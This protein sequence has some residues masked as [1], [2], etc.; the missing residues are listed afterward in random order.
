MRLQLRD[1]LNTIQRIYGL[2]ELELLGHESA[3]FEPCE[4][5]CENGGGCWTHRDT[6]C[7]CVRSWYG[8]L[9]YRTAAR[10]LFLRPY[11]AHFCPVFLVFSRFSPS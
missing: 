8:P 10:T 7:T 5:S 11:L 2:S 1:T 6:V 4:L 9:N 3:E